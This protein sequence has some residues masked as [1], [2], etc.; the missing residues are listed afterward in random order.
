[1][2]SC[3]DGGLP[4]P[5]PGGLDLTPARAESL[6][7]Q[8]LRGGWRHWGQRGCGETRPRATGGAG[9]AMSNGEDA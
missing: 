1:M 7:P 9:A 6:G 5:D 3:P 4:S 2:T 8:L